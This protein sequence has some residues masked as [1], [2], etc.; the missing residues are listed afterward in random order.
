MFRRHGD[1]DGEAVTLDSLGYAAHRAGEHA[2]AI[3][4]YRL[5]IEVFRAADNTYNEVNSMAGLGASHAALGEIDEARVAWN[6][7]LDLYR[8]QSRQAGI[9]RIEQWL[10]ELDRP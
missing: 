2:V 6:R 8:A 10:A 4:H 3:D 7:A 1:T 9:D 5:A